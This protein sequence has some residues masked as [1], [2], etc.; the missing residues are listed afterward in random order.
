MVAGAVKKDLGLV[1]EAAECARMNDAVAVA[2]IV[3]PPRGRRFGIFAPEGIAAELRVGRKDLAFDLFEFLS[4]S[5]HRL[6][7]KENPERQKR[8][9][10]G[11]VRQQFLDG[12]AAQRKDA[13]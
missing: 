6:I 11:L 12:N 9:R 5:R 10:T 3:R 8:N 1:F 2:L 4:G 13:A 7:K